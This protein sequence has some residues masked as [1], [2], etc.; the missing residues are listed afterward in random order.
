MTAAAPK[1]PG[2]WRFSTAVYGRPGVKE[3]CLALQD[4]G[5]DVNIALWIVWTVITGRDP[6]P[7]LAQAE[8]LSALWR[9]RVV[10]RLRDARDRLKTVPAF[11][12]PDEAARLRQRVLATELDAERLQQTALA[13]LAPGC[14]PLDDADLAAACR[15][16]L[17]G[18]AAR[19]GADAPT[20]AFVETVFSAVKM[21]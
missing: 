18:Y 3:A 21:V 9:T 15:T 20:D 7:A 1:P 10:Q 14:P 19:A 16:R 17:A 5:L 8:D 2:L 4:A 13:A 11:I 6:A 12:D